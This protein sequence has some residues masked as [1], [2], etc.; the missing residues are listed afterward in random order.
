MNSS[1][2]EI[3]LVALDLAV[4][5]LLLFLQVVVALLHVFETVGD[6]VEL[7]GKCSTS[8]ERGGGVLT[9]RGGSSQS[10]IPVMFHKPLVMPRWMRISIPSF[11][12]IEQKK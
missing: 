9:A 11:P 2:L 6:V 12:A 5:L 7:S 4:R 8:A 1:H 3:L 10:E